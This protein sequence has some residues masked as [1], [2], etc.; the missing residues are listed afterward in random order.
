MYFIKNESSTSTIGNHNNTNLKQMRIFSICLGLF[1]LFNISAQNNSVAISLLPTDLDS[2]KNVLPYAQVWVDTT[3]EVDF[4][5][6]VNED[7]EAFDTSKI[8]QFKKW[9]NYWLKITLHNASTTEILRGG[10]WVDFLS[11]VHLFS[12]SLHLQNGVDV[13]YYKRAFPSN[14]NFLPIRLLPNETR[15]FYCQIITRHLFAKPPTWVLVSHAK[16]EQRRLQSFQANSSMVIFRSFFIGL[17]LFVALFALAQY[18]FLK[19]KALVFYA[20]FLLSNA[21]FFLR[22]LENLTS[23]NILFAPFGN[24]MCFEAP[25][26]YII[27][28]AYIL[29]FNSFLNISDQFLPLSR[30]LKATALIVIA[31]AVFDIGLE[32]VCGVKASLWLLDKVRLLFFGV[33]LFLF[34]LIFFKLRSRL[35]NWLAAGIF[36]VVIGALVTLLENKFDADSTPLWGGLLRELRFDG[37]RIYFYDLKAALL[38][39]ILCFYIALH[40]K[41]QSEKTAKIASENLALQLESERDFL[42][43]KLDDYDEK[44]EIKDTQNPKLDTQNPFILR[45]LKI[46][47]DN[48]TNA[49]FSAKH[50]A[51]AMNL[52]PQQ[53]TRRWK[54]DTKHTPYESILN[55]RLDHAKTLLLTTDEPISNIS[56]A[57]GFSNPANFSTAFSEKFGLSPT[58][59]KVLHGK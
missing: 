46:I 39:E 4:K 37:F 23:W 30:V 59:F 9:T 45:G 35:G 57:S 15:S 13:P 53:L 2:G 5:E 27:Y 58:K 33:V 10:F 18:R 31:I 52:S 55:R 8:P 22:S 50:F 24:M 7:F 3:Q 14:Q 12:D 42:Q 54:T 32:L 51:R 43:K 19:E 48:F 41:M 49:D 17:L 26:T 40:I 38:I 11:E 36:V 21:L 34:Y 6:F 25:L 47:D 56:E 44:T 20:V 1:T 28:A 16:E 29:F